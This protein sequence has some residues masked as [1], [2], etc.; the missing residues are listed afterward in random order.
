MGRFNNFSNFRFLPYKKRMGNLEASNYYVDPEGNV[1]PHYL[2][3]APFARFSIIKL[4]PNQYYGR[5][6]EFEYNPE[7][8]CYYQD[9]GSWIHKS[10]F[11]NKETGYTIAYF[12]NIDDTEVCPDLEI[13]GDRAYRLS[14]VEKL[15]FFDLAEETHNFIIEQLNLNSD[16]P[17]YS[18]Y[19]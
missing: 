12:S 3:G 19:K 13:L 2:D 14:N 6:E 9:S 17:Y 18:Y 4:E 8:E 10:C 5:E 11:K 7:N 15:I 1:S 16:D